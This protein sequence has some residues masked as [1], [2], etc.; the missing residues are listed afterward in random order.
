LRAFSTVRFSGIVA[1]TRL[2][3]EAFHDPEKW[4]A[5]SAP[6]LVRADSS[7]EGEVAGN[8]SASTLSALKHTASIGST[9]NEIERDETAAIIEHRAFLQWRRLS[10]PKRATPMRLAGR[11]PRDRARELARRRGVTLGSNIPPALHRIQA[12]SNVP[13]RKQ[14]TVRAYPLGFESCRHG[15]AVLCEPVFATISLISENAGETGRFYGPLS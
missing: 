11:I 13:D 5:F 14:P 8:W 7:A 6:G 9:F 1:S 15:V 12:Q 3:T 10:V 4:R 2:A